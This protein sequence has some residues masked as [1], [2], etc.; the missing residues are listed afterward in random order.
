MDE[1]AARLEAA[2]LAG[3]KRVII[4]L[5]KCELLSGDPEWSITPKRI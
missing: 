2:T 3:T 1:M 5:S 4:E